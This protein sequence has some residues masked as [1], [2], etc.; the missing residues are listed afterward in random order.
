MTSHHSH[1]GALSQTADGAH[2]I[3]PDAVLRV[4][5]AFWPPKCCSA[6]SSSISSGTCRWAA[7]RGD[8]ASLGRLAGERRRSLDEHQHAQRNSIRGG[9]P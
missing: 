9:L 2:D 3:S 6:P 4:G 1:G 7:R 8:L 5:L